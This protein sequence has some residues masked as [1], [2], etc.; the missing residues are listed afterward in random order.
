MSTSVLC[1]VCGKRKKAMSEERDG[2]YAEPPVIRTL[3]PLSE[4]GMFVVVW[5]WVR[6]DCKVFGFW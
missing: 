6:S 4:Y 2:A 1:I 5:V 3:R